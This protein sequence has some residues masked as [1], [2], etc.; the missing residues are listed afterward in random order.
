MNP[1][2]TFT[3]KAVRR[4][5]SIETGSLTAPSREAAAA[6]VTE[7]GGFLVELAAERGRGKRPPSVDDIALGLRSLATLLASG[8]PVGRALTVLGE[9][10]PP[11][12]SEAVPE[13]RRRVVEGD[14]L[15]RALDL[16]PLSLPGHAIGIVAAGEAG[17]GLA[18]AVERAAALMEARAANYH[19]LLSTLTYPIILAV[20]GSAS[21][22]LL[23]L[24]VLP[25]FAS[26]LADADQ[27]LP[28]TTRVVLE[29]GSAARLVFWPAIITTLIASACWR[30][31]IIRPGHLER[32]HRLLRGI[33]VI[34]SVRRSQATAHGCGTLAALLEAGVPI[35]AALPH[36]ARATG[37]AAQ[38]ADILRAR[39]R[40]GRGERISS[41]LA[42]VDALTPTAI[43]LVRLGEETGRLDEMLSSAARLES[44][45]AVRQL[46]RAVRL[47]EPA[48][49]LAF[50][51]VVLVVAAALLQ[52]MYG[53][54]PTH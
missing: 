3:F 52:A 4:D 38:E 10:A 14:S 36:A 8:I 48:M 40:I 20:A 2:A 12:W 49:I 31:W 6:A 22:A 28:V 27:A 17:S 45:A 5:G 33:P 23:V 51:S 37:D 1:I 29:F 15:A 26:L 13:L 32:W 46:Q 39:E 42:T 53:L 11:S 50:G 21:V 19:A 41:A 25:R 24:G 43:Q 18:G 54:R 30:T 44:V 9:L 7:R 16:S 35:A 47:L 34:G